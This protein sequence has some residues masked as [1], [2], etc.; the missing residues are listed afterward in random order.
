M[1][2]LREWVRDETE[3]T[4]LRAVAQAAEISHTTIVNFLAEPGRRRHVRVRRSLGM[5]YLA[6]SA[7]TAQSVESAADVLLTGLPGDHVEN[8]RQALLGFVV[9]LH[10]RFA[11]R[12]PPWAE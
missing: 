4:S 1:D 10:Q 9:E 8:A 3:R 7:N 2:T 11:G 12:L 6:E 5:L